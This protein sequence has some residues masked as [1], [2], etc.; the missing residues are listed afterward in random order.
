MNLEALRVLATERG[1][2]EARSLGRAE[3]IDRLAPATLIERAKEAVAHAVEV[4]EEK[5]HHLRER[6]R[7]HVPGATKEPDEAEE[8]PRMPARQTFDVPSST[9]HPVV[10]ADPVVHP[11]RAEAADGPSCARAASTPPSV[12]SQ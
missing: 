7:S 1:V 6:V 11:H 10:P 5:A 8:P 4:V 9:V 12:T 3:L 2:G